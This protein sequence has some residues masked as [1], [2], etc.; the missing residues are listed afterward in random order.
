MKKVN[1]TTAIASIALAAATFAA[2]LTAQAKDFRNVRL[3][4]VSHPV[5]TVH[6]HKT[7]SPVYSFNRGY[8]TGYG[9]NVSSLDLQIAVLTRQLTGLRRTGR[10]SI[11]Y[12]KRVSNLELRISDLR[13]QRSRFLNVR[14]NTRNIRSNR[15]GF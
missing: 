14:S 2:P 3:A 1:L 12:N 6:I 15:R 4:T 10:R 7:V 13:R 11:G 8:N 9:H 5:K